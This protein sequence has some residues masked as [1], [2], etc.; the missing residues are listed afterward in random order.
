MIL[1]KQSFHEMGRHKA[2]RAHIVPEGPIFRAG[3]DPSVNKNAQTSF[4]MKNGFEK[5]MFFG[6]KNSVVLV[7]C[8]IKTEV[9]IWSLRGP[10]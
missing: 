5:I 1:F 8:A 6:V 2:P 7:V 4:L 9:A 3:S 10:E